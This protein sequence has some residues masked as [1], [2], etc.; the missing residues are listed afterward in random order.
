MKNRFTEIDDL[1]GL[2]IFFMILVHT[3]VYFLT[4]SFMKFLWNFSEW[5]VAGFI[6]CSSFVYFINSKN[7]FWNEKKIDFK[8]YWQYLLK[9]LK[10]LIIPYYIFLLVFISLLLLTHNKLLNT[11]YIIFSTF[12]VGG[13]DI[14]W[15]VLLFLIFALMFPLIKYLFENY[16][17]IFYLGF[18]LSF[19][20]LIY[21][22]FIHNLNFN[23]RFIFWLPWSFIVFYTVLFTDYSLREKSKLSNKYFYLFSILFFVF[24]FLFSFI[25][26]QQNYLNLDQISNKYPPNL[27][28]ISFGL[29]GVLGFYLLSKI[30]IFNPPAG[31]LRKFL[32]FLSLNSY[33]IYF[34][35]YTILYFTASWFVKNSNW[36]LFTIF[37]FITSLISQKTFNLILKK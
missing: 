31:G 34:I 22:L 19:L 14:S 8:L 1:R 18:F 17:K 12:L 9:R 16:K 5:S 21:F 4:D 6:F 27:Y 37:V 24:S 26:L 30:G 29:L 36:F 2:A 7:N 20:S 35:H 32:N 10:R 15:L 13:V 23:Y 33:S 25:Y 11:K 3:S 28:H